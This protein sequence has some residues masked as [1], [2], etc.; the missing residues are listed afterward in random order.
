[1]YTI[2]TTAPVVVSLSTRIEAPLATVWSVHTDVDAWPAW[3]A[4][5]DQARLDGPMAVGTPFT[6]LT[7]GMSITSTVREVVP[8]ERIVWDGTVQ[9]IAGIHVW[10]FEAAGGGVVVRTEES[11]SGAPVAADPDTL[12]TAL[13]TSLQNWLDC[14]KAHAEQS[15]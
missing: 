3:N 7:H 11:W 6:W 8:G 1:M 13:R 5:V 15:A 14:L 4:G 2:D 10:T 9:G 12:T